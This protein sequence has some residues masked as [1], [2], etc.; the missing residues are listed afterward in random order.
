MAQAQLTFDA[1]ADARVRVPPSVVH[2]NFDAETVLL[3]LDTGRYHGLRGTGG[4]MFELLE[5]TGSVRVAA[6]TVA[7]EFGEP[8]ERV[9]RDVAELC[10]SLLARGLIEVDG[11]TP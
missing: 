1:L 6:T 7:E 2:R 8:V 11:P 3:N 10:S 5:K 4:R 9:A